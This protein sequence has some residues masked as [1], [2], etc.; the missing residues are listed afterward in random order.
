MFL[1]KNSSIEIKKKDFFLAEFSVFRSR[2]TIDVKQMDGWR[3]PKSIDGERDAFFYFVSGEKEFLH[4]PVWQD[5]GESHFDSRYALRRIN[6]MFD[7]N[8]N[9][10]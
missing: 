3:V 9:F 1:K 6:C 5:F 10:I 4:P 8:K 2:K 7:G